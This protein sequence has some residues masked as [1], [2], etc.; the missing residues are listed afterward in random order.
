VVRR[1]RIAAIVAALMIVVLEAFSYATVPL[2]PRVMGTARRT[3]TIFA[4][5]AV[6][7]DTLL[8]TRIQ[9]LAN[10]TTSKRPVLQ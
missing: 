2:L 8:L 7:T 10:D 9:P 1:L 3:A 4:E 5:P 6:Q